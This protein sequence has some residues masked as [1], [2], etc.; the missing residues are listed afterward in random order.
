MSVRSPKIVGTYA[1]LELFLLLNPNRGGMNP[2]LG[3]SIR[4]FRTRTYHRSTIRNH[5]ERLPSTVFR[6]A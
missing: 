6:L 2:V 3:R 5:A 4:G 1:D